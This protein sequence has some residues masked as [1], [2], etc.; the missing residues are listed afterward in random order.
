MALTRPVGTFW[1]RLPA[2]I[3]RPVKGGVRSGYVALLALAFV[4]AC[5]STTGG[6]AEPVPEA[7]TTTSSLVIEPT[8]TTPPPPRLLVDVGVDLENGV[9]IAAVVMPSAAALAG[10]QAYWASVNLDLGGVGGELDVELFERETADAAFTSNVAVI[11]LDQGAVEPVGPIFAM[12]PTQTIDSV[13]A[14][15]T[16]D[17]TR[18]TLGAVVSAASQLALD[19]DFVAE[20]TLGVVAGASCPFDPM[21]Y[22]LTEG[23]GADFVLVCG[24]PAEA[25]AALADID[26]VVFLTYEAWSPD[27]AAE[28][29]EDTYV[30]GAVPEPG[31]D[32][33]AAEIL[34][35]VADEQ[36]WDPEFVRGYTAALTTHL[37]LERAYA[38]GDLTRAGVQTAARTMDDADPGFG[39]RDSVTVAVPD[40]D[41]PSGLRTVDRIDA[42]Q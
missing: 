6:Q 14:G 23:A 12:A 7:P 11:S 25:V 26:G 9:I 4:T 37:A 29:P 30:L 17:A 2:M 34:A 38:A 15:R 41:S 36:P 19:A 20:G 31:T 16:L 24:T 10:H 5:T 3:P 18:P 42:D 39:P 40:E 22:Q 13:A 35:T 28:L 8:A 33:P 1:G 21:T 32:A 27:I